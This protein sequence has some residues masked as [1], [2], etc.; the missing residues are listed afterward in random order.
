MQGYLSSWIPN[1]ARILLTSNLMTLN[2]IKVR[3]LRWQ[4]SD[5]AYLMPSPWRSRE[6]CWWEDHL[7]SLTINLMTDESLSHSQ[8]CTWKIKKS[9]LLLLSHTHFRKCQK[10]SFLLNE[11]ELESWRLSKIFLSWNE[12]FMPLSVQKLSSK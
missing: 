2:Y 8:S 12:I 5:H 6:G 7:S 11:K 10:K 1:K 9:S 3:F 4:I